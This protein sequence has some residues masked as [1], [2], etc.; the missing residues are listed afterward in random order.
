MHPANSVIIFT[1]LSGL[2][3]G[4]M[5]MIGL[6]YGPTDSVA[7]PLAGI[8]A[9]A[10]AG[11]GLISS[12]FHLGNP[13][14]ALLAFSQWRSSW[15]SREGCVSVVLMCAFFAHVVLW[16]LNGAPIIWLGAVC[17]VLAVVAICCTAMIYAQLKTVPRWN[18]A[19]TLPMFVGY[20]LGGG[21]LLSA[22]T[23]SFSGDPVDR[24]F[25][26]ALIVASMF[27]YFHRRMTSMVTLKS[28]GSS[29]ETAT[30]L[31]KFGKVRLLE[32]PHSQP[33]YLMKEMVFRVGRKHAEKLAVI[34][35]I[36]GVF[37]PLFL[38]VAAII[39]A[40]PAAPLLLLA[41]VLHLGGAMSSRWLFFAEAEHVVG[42]YY[43]QR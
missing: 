5:T 1:T 8:L 3:F 40:L 10:L 19:W 9:L 36:A 18:S 32:S 24:G 42:L 21:V 23:R 37:A 16:Y 39:T 12:T 38:T 2:G 11:A 35:V 29:P 33:N 43:G 6:G 28:S 27:M 22:L 20:G 34:T 7:G 4:L 17:A 41:T 15:L 31:G 30:G 25:A 26:M 13:Q 14:R